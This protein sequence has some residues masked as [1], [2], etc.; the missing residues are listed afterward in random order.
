MWNK[1][2]DENMILE[3]QVNLAESDRRYF[4]IIRNFPVTS[5]IFLSCFKLYN[6]HLH[7]SFRSS[8]PEVFLGKGVLRICSKFTGE[9]PSRSVIWIKLQWNHT[10]VW[11]F[12]CEFLAYFQTPFSKNTSRRLLLNP[13]WT[14]KHTLTFAT[15]FW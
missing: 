2:K 1:N 15:F 13:S 12:S 7:Q 9:H 11:V 3:R 10:S 6:G 5:L 14:M 4:Y 8:P